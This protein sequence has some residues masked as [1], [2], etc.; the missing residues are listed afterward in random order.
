MY[1]SAI[2][3]FKDICLRIN[4]DSDPVNW[5]YAQGLVALSSAIE[6]DM[7]HIR[8]SIQTLAA[9]QQKLEEAVRGLQG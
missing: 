6:Q 3:C 2:N 5:N 8:S 7:Q 9:N 4:H 1:E